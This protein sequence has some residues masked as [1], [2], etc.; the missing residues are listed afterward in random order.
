MHYELVDCTLLSMG[1]L[2]RTYNNLRKW[3]EAEQLRVQAM[4]ISK[5]VLAIKVDNNQ[6]N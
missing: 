2:A 6:I 4:D 5:K 1:N 3:N